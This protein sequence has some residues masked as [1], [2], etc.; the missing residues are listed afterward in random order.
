MKKDKTAKA[1][2]YAYRLFSIRSRSEKELRNRLF[3][4]GF[5]RATVSSVITFFQEKNIIDDFKFAK[6][7]IDSRMR[8]SPKGE[9]L[10]RKELREKGIA[11]SLIDKA[12]SEGNLDEASAVVG[13]AEKKLKT[14]GKLPKE[15]ARKRLFAFLAR[16][17][18]RFEIIEGSIR[19]LI[20]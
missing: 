3:Q 1:I 12:L 11:R 16:R 6:L 5:D 19:E 8:R 10:L 2:A 17:G 14:L 18:F 15:K 20:G 13:L 7:W 4:K 9:M